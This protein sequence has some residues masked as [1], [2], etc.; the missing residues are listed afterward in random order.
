MILRDAPG[1]SE[2]QDALK[3]EDVREIVD[4][5]LHIRERDKKFFDL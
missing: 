4:S 5:L 2:I 3:N 1:S